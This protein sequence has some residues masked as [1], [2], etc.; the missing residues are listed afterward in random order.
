MNHTLILATGTITEGQEQLIA[1]GYVIS[2]ILLGA[3]SAFGLARGQS[4]VTYVLGIIVGVAFVGYGLYILVA[5]PT[6]VFISYKLFFIP[7]LAILAI[8]LNL[9]RRARMRSAGQ[10][11]NAGQAP[12]YG[13]RPGQ[14][15]Y[16]GPPPYGQQMPGQQMPGQPAGYP[17]NQYGQPAQPGA[18][19]RATPPQYGPPQSGPPQYRPPQYGTAPATGG[20]QQ[21]PTRQPPPAPPTNTDQP[22]WPQ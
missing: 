8:V 6:E 15:P 4:K 12:G 17:P 7:V 1:V 5:N 18:Y 20:Y 22:L 16:G 10:F 13:P 21:E 2:G 9:A 14:A 19:G 3:M 11:G